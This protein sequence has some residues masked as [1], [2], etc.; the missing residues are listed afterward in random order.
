MSPY[1]VTPSDTAP[2]FN[3]FSSCSAAS[4][5]SYLSSI[6]SSEFE[7]CL[8]NNK[9]NNTEFMENFCQGTTGSN[10]NL[11]AQCK[12]HFGDSA[13]VCAN[14][15]PGIS[16]GFVPFDGCRLDS[17]D[18]QPLLRCSDGGSCST[19]NNVYTIWPGTPCLNQNETQGNRV[20]FDGVCSDPVDFC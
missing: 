5:A 6:P 15:M 9:P 10:Y 17:S 8:Y 2:D 14:G 13:F 3:K 16:D 7:E 20:C 11:T 18:V 19:T 1:F 4:I 12:T